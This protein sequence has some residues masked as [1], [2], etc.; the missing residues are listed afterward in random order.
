MNYEVIIKENNDYDVI[1]EVNNVEII[2]FSSKGLKAKEGDIIFVEITPF[3]DFEIYLSS[4]VNRTI[5]HISGYQYKITGILDI[6]KGGV[7]SLF[8]IELEELYD[9]GFL[10]KKMVEVHILRFNIYQS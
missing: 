1:I 8:F 7:D 9:Y 10:D 5:E 3:C 2:C 4:S 6:D